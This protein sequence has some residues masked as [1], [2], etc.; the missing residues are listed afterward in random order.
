[1][2]ITITVNQDLPFE[3]MIT[4]E[5]KEFSFNQWLATLS[6]EDQQEWEKQCRIH[7]IAVDAAVAAG[8]AKITHNKNNATTEWR[9]QEIHMHW[10]NTIS[11][12]D[13]A[14][15]HSFWDRYHT[16]AAGRTV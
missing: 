1:M 10:M 16:A 9:N 13:H 3:K 4:A 7:N 11:A 8:D 6:P 2:T 14:S 5:Y 12:E 15:Y